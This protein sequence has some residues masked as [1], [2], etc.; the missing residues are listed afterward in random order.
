MMVRGTVVLGGFEF[1]NAF[2]G[3]REAQNGKFALFCQIY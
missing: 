3:N 1:L 2:S